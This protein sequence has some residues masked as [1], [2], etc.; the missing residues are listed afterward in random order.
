MILTVGVLKGRLLT[1]KSLAAPALP[2]WVL[3]GLGRVLLVLVL[4]LVLLL[5]LLLP[6]ALGAMT[7]AARCSLEP[8]TCSCTLHGI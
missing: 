7:D 3:P 4:V 8:E 5:L 2:L 6:D 1:E